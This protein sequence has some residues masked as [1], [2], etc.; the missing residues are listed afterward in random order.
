MATADEILQQMEAEANA[1]VLTIDNDLR[2]IAIPEDVAILGVESDDDVHRLRFRM[3]KMCGEF[4]LSEFKLRVNIMNAGN[5]P[6]L[7]EVKD[8]A[9]EGEAITFS[10]LVGRTAAKYKGDV[11]FSVCAKLMDKDGVVQQEFNT[12]PAKLPVLEGLE[13]SEAVVQLHPDIIEA[14][15]LRLS[16]LETS[17]GVTDEQIANALSAYLAENPVQPGATQ[18]QAEQIE[19]NKKA[20]EELQ[21]GG[22]GGGIAEETDPTVPAWA[23]QPSKPTY[24]AAEVGALPATTQIPTVPATLPNP[25]P[26]VI[27]GVSYDGSE[28]KEITIT[29][30][31]GG[32]A[33]ETD[34]TVPAWAKQPSKPTYTAAEVGALPATTQIPT[35]PETLPNPQPIVINGVSYDGS[36]RKEITVQAEAGAGI[37]DATPSTTTTYS[38]VKIDELLNEQKKANA[39]QDERL[40]T[41]EQTAPSG[42]SGLT[43]A[44]INALDGMFKVAAYASDAADAYAAFKA[45]FGVVSLLG[46]SAV[47][48]GDSVVVGTDVTTLTGITVTANYSDGKA[49]T[50]TDYTIT[51]EISEGTNTLT[52]GYG[53]KYTTITVIGV[54][55][56]SEP[57]TMTGITAAYTGGNVP[58]GT[59]LTA[60]T[61]VTVT[62]TYSDGSTAAVTGYT[63]SGEIAEGENTI[64]VSYGTFTST[65]T[66]T[67]YTVVAD[68]EWTVVREIGASADAYPYVGVLNSTHENGVNSGETGWKST[69]YIEVPDG[70]TSISRI[71]SRP[72]DYYGSWYDADKN[73]IGEV[74]NGTYGGNA[75]YGGGYTDENGVIWIAVP[76]TAKYIRVSCRSAENYTSLTFMHNPKLD[77]SVMPVYDKLYHY[78]Y[79]AESTES[80]IVIDDYLKC[81]GMAYAQIRPILRRSITFYGADYAEVSKSATANNLGNNVVIPTDAVY[82]KF[83]TN[84]K[85]ATNSCSFDGIGLIKFTESELTAW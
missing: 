85:H 34:P 20:I 13:V 11:K 14:I 44:Q 45:A 71:T 16:K 38:S 69:D 75:T 82:M 64:T 72:S 59:A 61:G 74:F 53:G 54:D 62:A 30:P 77:E 49:V 70:A 15:L 19:A 31:D 35:V 1:P 10:W 33:T 6:D 9:V 84:N 48:S 66:V 56:G 37:D 23:K 57:V 22:A 5:E 17:G 47:Y 67:G 50:V 76:S 60:L 63:L 2:T 27:N 39:K 32:I 3:P 26:I 42:T 21:K 46:I 65:I 68:E 43:V 4:D 40:S 73:Y 12:T 78:T 41:L 18:E 83:T 7:Y 24:T 58:V 80:Y 52:I 79:D 51:G 8:K 36:E 55:D 28:K 29:A 25:Q 81:S